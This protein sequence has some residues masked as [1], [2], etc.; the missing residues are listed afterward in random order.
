MLD[1]EEINAMLLGFNELYND[2]KL[3]PL[4][5]VEMNIKI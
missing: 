4:N 3:E 5:E 1:D 2:I